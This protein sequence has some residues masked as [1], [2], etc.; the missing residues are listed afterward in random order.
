MGKL[1][2]RHF[3][4]Q[5]LIDLYWKMV[6]AGYVEYG[7]NKSSIV[8]VPQGG[9]ISPILSNLVLNELDC[10]IERLIEENLL[11]NQG[12]THT[13]RNPA[14]YKLDD[15]IQTIRKIETKKKNR[16][17]EIDQTLL[18]ERNELIKLRSRTPSTIPN[19]DLSKFYYVRYA[20]D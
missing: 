19:G 3:H 6:R 13:L 1:L 18:N 12:R 7:K 4:D 2:K 5:R 20:D 8:G 17:E 10:F 15:R 16:G 11:K 14:Y 9:I